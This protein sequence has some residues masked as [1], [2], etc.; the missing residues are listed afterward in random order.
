MAGSYFASAVTIQSAN[1]VVVLNSGQMDGLTGLRAV[2]AAWVV[3]FHYST[4]QF[5]PL[6]LQHDLPILHFG[7]LGVDLF[8]MLSG[9]VIWHVH[10]KDFLEPSVLK[11]KRFVLLRL[12]RLYPVYLFTLL[13][14]GA[15]FLL[16][17]RIS[18]WTFN[19]A[20]SQPRQFAADLTMLQT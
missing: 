19:P 6:G 8:F 11:L 14:L 12:A 7:Y 15:M 10:A 13:L 17:T 1:P 5:S 3:A 2:A 4:E 16:S 20:Q 9:F 18:G